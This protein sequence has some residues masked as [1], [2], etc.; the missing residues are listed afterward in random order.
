MLSGGRRHG[1]SRK[2]SGR[3]PM[4]NLG[5]FDFGQFD[6]GQFNLGQYCVPTFS[7]DDLDQFNQSQLAHVGL[8]V[9]VV[10]CLCVGLQMLGPNDL[11]PTIWNV[12]C[13]PPPAHHEKIAVYFLMD[14]QMNEI[15][16]ILSQICLSQNCLNQN[17]YV[18]EPRRNTKIFRAW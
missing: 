1:V 4:V 16:K 5:Q 14:M 18:V 12:C 9:C 17:R 7:V 11:T 13:S 8:C 2:I 15:R 10:V 6:S 3:V